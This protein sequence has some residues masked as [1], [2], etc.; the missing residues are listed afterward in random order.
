MF[1]AF[2]DKFLNAASKAYTRM[3]VHCCE[4]IMQQMSG[5]FSPW[6]SETY[7]ITGRL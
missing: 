1:E 3:K 4:E 2:E 5:I 6:V 7:N